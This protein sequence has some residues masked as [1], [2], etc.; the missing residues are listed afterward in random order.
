MANMQSG[1]KILI[2]GGG[3][4]GL[5]TALTLHRLGLKSI[6]VLEQAS[7][8]RA[9]GACLTIWENGWKSLDAL[10]VGDTL[11]R[12]HTRIQRIDT[13]S[14]TRGLTKSFDPHQHEVRCVQR[15]KLLE[16]LAQAV[17]SNTIRFS[18]KISAIHPRQDNSSIVTLE[19]GS[20]ISPKVVIGCDGV[21]STVAK[22]LGFGSP[23]LA[24]RSSFLGL[25]SFPQGHHFEAKFVQMWGNGMVAAFA[26]CNERDVYWY[27]SRKS[28]PRDAEI[29]YNAVILQEEAQHLA[30]DFGNKE[31]MEVIQRSIPSSLSLAILKHRYLWPFTAG[32]AQKGSVTVVGDAMHPM[33]PDLVQ[34]KAL[35]L[36]DSITL[37][38]FLAEVDLEKPA[39]IEVALKKYVDKRKGRAFGIGVGSSVSGIMQSGSWWLPKLIRDKVVM[40]TISPKML[41]YAEYDCGT[42]RNVS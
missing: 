6:T 40:N 2:A 19:D 12:D 21:N 22:W 14:T 13:I 27:L 36:E 39:E 38:R 1:S 30:E 15:K 5:A 16:A 18:S 41:R 34:G 31:I 11:R 10:G 4:G 29:S 24:G 20:Q 3:I 7:S 32:K 28:L 33:T 42:L 37:G 25:G 9:T 35:A 17:P 8:L 23:N 26:P